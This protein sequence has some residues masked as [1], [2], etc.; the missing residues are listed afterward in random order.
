M[1]KELSPALKQL[2]QAIAK[3]PNPVR[4]AFCGFDLWLDVL[5]SGRIGSRGF[6]R[7]GELATGDEEK[8]T[9]VVPVMVVGDSIVVNFDPT[10]PPNAFR[11]A[12]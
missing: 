10:L 3:H 6:K 2:G 8:D 11:L 12:P 5:G 1:N 4:V 9:L 7:G